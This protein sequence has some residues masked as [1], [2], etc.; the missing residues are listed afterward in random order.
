MEEAESTMY[1]ETGITNCHSTE[2]DG[3]PIPMEPLLLPRICGVLA[4]RYGIQG[5]AILY[6]G[7]VSKAELQED[8]KRLR[9]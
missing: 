1:P 9:E 6:F 3:T 7:N 8:G 2:I 5:A 4:T